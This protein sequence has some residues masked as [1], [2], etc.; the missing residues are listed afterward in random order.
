MSRL[1]T[2]SPSDSKRPS[3]RWRRTSMPVQT[4]A[5]PQSSAKAPVSANSAA[6]SPAPNALASRSGP[7]TQASAPMASSSIDTPTSAASA[8]QRLH[9][10]PSRLTCRCMSGAAGGPLGSFDRDVKLDSSGRILRRRN[11][12][13]HPGTVGNAGGHRDLQLVAQ[14]LGAA[15]RAPQARLAPALSAPP[16]SPAGA[17]HRYRQWDRDAFHGISRGQPD[18]GVQRRPVLLGKKGTAHAVNGRG[19]RWKVQDR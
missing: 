9:R 15:A 7:S 13:L 5:P 4:W 17:A 19:D 8:P 11:A 3:G 18:G 14:H 16:A 1:T 10:M 6:K 2:A 12:E